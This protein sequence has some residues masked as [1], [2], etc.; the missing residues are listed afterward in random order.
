M[1]GWFTNVIPVEDSSFTMSGTANY[2]WFGFDA[3]CINGNELIV[4]APG[5]RTPDSGQAAGAVYG[6]ST[7]NKTLLFN[8]ESTEAQGKLG[9]SLAYNKE[10]KVLAVG[11]PSKKVDDLVSA[12]QVYLYDLSTY[13]TL[14]FSEHLNAIRSNERSSRFGKQLLW[15]KQT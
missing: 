6:F 10:L 3:E 12:G 11:A 1:L 5:A 15:L 7:T 2:Q 9:W 8:I 13:S 4:S 14:S